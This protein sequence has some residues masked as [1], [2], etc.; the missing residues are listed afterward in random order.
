MAFDNNTRKTPLKP[1]VLLTFSKYTGSTGFKSSDKDH[2]MAHDGE[3]MQKYLLHTTVISMPTVLEMAVAIS[4][5]GLWG[6]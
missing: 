4:W 5:R 3:R 2:Q 6:Y 1:L